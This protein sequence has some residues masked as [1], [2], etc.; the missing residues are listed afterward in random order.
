[1]KILRA[2]LWQ[3]DLQ[4]RAEEKKKSTIGMGSN[5]WGSQIRYHDCTAVVMHLRAFE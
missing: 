3:Q 4:K 1:M 5:S 2:K